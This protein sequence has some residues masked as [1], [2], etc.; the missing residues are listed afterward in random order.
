M[1]NLASIVETSVATL[2]TAQ[3]GT[4]FQLNVV[5][6]NSG[7]V[8]P[9]QLRS[10]VTGNTPS[11]L[12]EIGVDFRYPLVTVYCDKLANTLKER[13]RTFS[14]TAHV[15]VDV[16]FSQDR[17]QDIQIVLETYVSAV[18]DILDTSRGDL[19][20]GMFYAG[21]Y[22]VVFNPLKKGGKC[23]LQSA[24]VSLDINVNV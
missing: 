7:P 10:V 12:L 14:G 3:V 11:E 22:E 6:Q 23:Y 4:D 5:A 16:R 1:A 13:F 20:N 21:G 24:K 2:L 18:C 9:V 19:G 15:V 17:I 8:P